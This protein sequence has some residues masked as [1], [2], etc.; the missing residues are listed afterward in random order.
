MLFIY[1]FRCLLSTAFIP[2]YMIKGQGSLFSLLRYQWFIT[3]P[4][5]YYRC[6]INIC[7]WMYKTFPF[8]YFHYFISVCF[9]CWTESS[10]KQKSSSSPSPLSLS[11]LTKYLAFLIGWESKWKM[12]LT[13]KRH[14]IFFFFAC[15]Q[16]KSKF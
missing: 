10:M 11:S 15:K 14:T 6:S 4:F 1:I 2:C 16:P 7:W 8:L 3:V 13:S 5:T 9:L 12:K